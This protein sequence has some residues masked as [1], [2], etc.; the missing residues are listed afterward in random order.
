[1]SIGCRL[2]F[3]AK[4]FEKPYYM[5][6]YDDEKIRMLHYGFEDNGYETERSY[7]L[8]LLSPC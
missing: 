5:L 8:I 4:Y 2:M 3:I 1:M 6:L 7:V